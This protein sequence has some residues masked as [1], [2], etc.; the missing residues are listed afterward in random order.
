M[1]YSWASTVTVRAVSHGLF[2][3]AYIFNYQPFLI[4]INCIIIWHFIFYLL[5]NMKMHRQKHVT[6]FFFL[7]FTFFF[8]PELKTSLHTFCFV[9]VFTKKSFIFIVL[10]LGRYIKIQAFNSTLF[11][12]LSHNPDRP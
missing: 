6:H 11:S 4:Q 2:G 7:L 5:I 9:F 10:K 3:N 12:S 1:G 8:F